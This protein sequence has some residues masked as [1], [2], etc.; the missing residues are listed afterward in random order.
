MAKYLL[1]PT[2]PTPNGPLHLGHISGPYLKV[3][4]LARHLRRAGHSAVV[5]SASDVWETHVLPKARMLGVTPEDVCHR[6]HRDIEESLKALD[7]RYDFYINPLDPP[8]RERLAAI[9]QD[10]IDS[11]ARRGNLHLVRERV[12]YSL[13]YHAP[14]VG[15]FIAGTCPYCGDDD[16][17]GFHCETCGAEISPEQMVDMRSD[18]PDDEIEFRDYQSVFLE[19]ND[20]G[21]VVDQLH[22]SCSDPKLIEI[23]RRHLERNGNLVRLTHP[24]NWGIPVR[25]PGASDESMIFSFPALFSLSLLCAEVAGP[26]LAELLPFEPVN[27]TT[28]ISAFGFDNTV[29]F[30]LGVLGQA[31]A[32]GAWRPFDRYL[33][34]YFFTLDGEKF[35]TSRGHAIWAK[36]ATERLRASSDLIRLY[37][38]SVNP[39]AA[40][41]D[42]S[43][44][45]FRRME[46]EFMTRFLA[47]QSRSGGWC[48][49]QTDSALS[50][51]LAMLLDSQGTALNPASL[52]MAASVKAIWEW[53]A[54]GGECGPT[55]Q[56]KRGFALLAYPLMP[57]MSLKLWRESGAAGEPKL[58]AL[59][60]PY[61]AEGAGRLKMA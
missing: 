48:R 55:P 57:E 2:M 7:I 39:E 14:V 22:R 27:D 33:T 45:A 40:P 61:A 60:M 34:N 10:V 30:F 52:Q 29:P 38:I 49:P 42:F 54:L 53:L 24:G 20:A 28:L 13:K 46:Q 44:E 56:W 1:I 15:S 6:F 16:A 17:G 31:L 18:L 58:S 36:D 43:T 4:V 23:A 50:N 9:C 11:N 41:S 35:S 47:V 19:V 8:H 51:R 5:S 12:P 32:G 37:I 25:F 26:K 21:A 59:H 3:D